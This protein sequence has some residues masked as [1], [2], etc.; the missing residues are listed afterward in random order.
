MIDASR[1][2]GSTSTTHKNIIAKVSATVSATT[3]AATAVIAV[4]I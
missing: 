3:A 2:R 1:F 4:E